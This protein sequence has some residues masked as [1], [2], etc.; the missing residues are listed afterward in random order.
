MWKLGLVGWKRPAPLPR[1]KT[2]R[3]E[4]CVPHP[5]DFVEW[6]ALR[7]DSHGFLQPWEPLWP[8]DHLSRGAFK[9][10]VRWARAEAEVDRALSFL[11]FRKADRV[12]VGGV[13]LSNIR[14]GPS[15]SATLGYWIGRKYVRQGYMT[16]ATEAMAHHAFT[17]MKLTRL[18]AA[19]LET[20]EASRALLASCGFSYEGIA[21]SYLEVNGAVRD[22]MLFARIK[23]DHV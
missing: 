13:T 21:R 17:R 14:R 11:I 20:N 7:R 3:L 4:M 8:K 2:E 6:K 19:C 23:S 18:E 15:Q 10:R 12:M 16:E 5:D 22:H 1:L 9:R